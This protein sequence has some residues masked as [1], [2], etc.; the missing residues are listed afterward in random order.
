MNWINIKE[1]IPPL[2]KDMYD[3][4]K[5]VLAFHTIHGI[6]FALFFIGDEN[7]V[8]LIKEEYDQSDY[9]CSADF[10]FN[11]YDGNWEPRSETDIDI[12]DDSPHFTN[13][14]TISHWM[15]LPEVP[16]KD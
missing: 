16:L 10:I 1:K 13:L 5:A 11:H 7:E 14:G 6:G 9:I 15:P 3:K 2:S 4:D 12:F 8:S